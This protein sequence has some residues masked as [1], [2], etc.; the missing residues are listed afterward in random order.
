MKRLKTDGHD[1]PSVLPLKLFHG[2]GMCVRWRT[3][4][5][6]AGSDT[7]QMNAI[8]LMVTHKAIVA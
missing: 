4:L 6:D 5:G 7:K 8:I 2:T 1:R 3:R